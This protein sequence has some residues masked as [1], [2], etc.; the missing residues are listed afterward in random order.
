MKAAVLSDIHGN[1][2][3][4]ETCMEEI[5][6]RDINK[7][8]F[9]GDY[10]G[11]LAYPQ[12][13]MALIKEL[14]RNYECYFV[15]G[16]KED[17]WIDYKKGSEIT[18][19][20]NN[21]TTG[22]L[23]YAYQNLTNEDILFFESLSHVQ[24][25]SFEG[26]PAI[27]AY[28]GSH[29]RNDQK[30]KLNTDNSAQLF[31][32]AKETIILCGHTHIRNE[33]M[34]DGRLLLNPGSAGVPLESQGKAQFMVLSGENST[35]N[36]EFIDLPYDVER[37]IAELHEENLFVKA[38]CWSRVTEEVLRYGNISHGTVLSRAMQ[39]LYN[40]TGKWCWPDIPEKYWE[41]AVEEICHS[42]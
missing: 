39:L 18:W 9:L 30:L 14:K 19:K 26:M 17:Y 15:R 5:H 4:L 28:H 22:M 21:S 8:I 40:D 32:D 11:E 16:N 25:I 7:L 13:T 42:T 37:V 33:L 6:R 29:N 36:Y 34:Q 12:K 10:V 1:H 41:K 2:I 31:L 38:P 3:A 24:I 20:D 23:L 35:W 27:A